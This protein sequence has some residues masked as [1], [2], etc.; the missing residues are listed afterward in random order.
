[1]KNLFHRKRSPFKRGHIATGN[2]VVS[3]SLRSA[4]PQRGRQGYRCCQLPTNLRLRFPEVLG[5]RAKVPRVRVFL[6]VSPV[7]SMALG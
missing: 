5:I 7:V 3:D 6:T 1:M 2:D 4:A